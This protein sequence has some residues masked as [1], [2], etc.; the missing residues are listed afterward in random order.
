MIRSAAW[1]K[2]PP[3][4]ELLFF[5]FDARRAGSFGIHLFTLLRCEG[6]IFLCLQRCRWRVFSIDGKG[7]GVGWMVP[8]AFGG[9]NDGCNVA[10]PWISTSRRVACFCRLGRRLVL[11]PGS[12]LPLHVTHVVPTACGV[13]RCCVELQ[14]MFRCCTFVHVVTRFVLTCHVS[15]AFVE[16]SLVSTDGRTF[17][18]LSCLVSRTFLRPLRRF[19]VS[20]VLR[21]CDATGLDGTAFRRPLSHFHVSNDP[22]LRVVYV[23]S[24]LHV[25]TRPPSC[26]H[27][28]FLLP[29]RVRRSTLVTTC[30][31]DGLGFGFVP[32][33]SHASTDMDLR[34]DLF[35]LA[36]L[37]LF[38]V[39]LVHP[40]VVPFLLLLLLRV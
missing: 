8:A 23:A 26:H 16:D 15:L 19:F 6:S 36:S 33:T 29:S 40:R 32:S 38:L 34:A 27:D 3:K 2:V 17:R 12:F 31:M 39:R 24:T 11:S 35:L 25:S 7:P 5:F 9:S 4:E 37:P 14:W 20:F 1:E 18:L 22:F 21:T 13:G 10:F 30:T 28:R